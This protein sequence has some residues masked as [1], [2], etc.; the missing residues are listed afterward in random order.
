ML[1]SHYSLGFKQHSLAR[2]V[3]KDACLDLRLSRARWGVAALRDKIVIGS[4]EIGEKK[5]IKYK[6]FMEEELYRIAYCR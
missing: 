4:H 1:R 2:H 5:G 6:T 3:L